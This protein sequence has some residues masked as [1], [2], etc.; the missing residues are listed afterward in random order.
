MLTKQDIAELVES[1]KRERDELHLQFHLF[2]AEARTEWAGLEEK[3]THFQHKAHAASA[4]A[5]E[6]AGEVGAAAKLVGEEMR[7][8]YRRI[9]ETL[10]AN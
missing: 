3:L 10:K 6:A 7:A 4:A 9:R 8:G 1:L 5:G 2:K